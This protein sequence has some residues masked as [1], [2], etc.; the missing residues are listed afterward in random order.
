MCALPHEIAEVPLQQTLE[1]L[2]VTGLVAGH[3]MNGIMDGIEPQ[4]L[5][6]FG[7]LEL[8]GG[9]A[10]LGVHPHLQVLLGAVGQHLAQQLGELGGVLGLLKGVSLVGLGDL[11]VALAVGHPAH[12]QVHPDFAALAVKVLAQALDDLLG[13]ALG[14]THHVLVGVRQLALG[15][16]LELLSRG[17]AD[18]ALLGSGLA[19]EHITADGANKFRHFSFLL[20]QNEIVVLIVFLGF[21]TMA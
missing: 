18:R 1:G 3:F 15:L 8:A 6:L 17:A 19:L 12:G 7:Q 2:A 11:G 4:L 10:V 14:H 16:F 21:L 5:G 13:S 9:S 20:L